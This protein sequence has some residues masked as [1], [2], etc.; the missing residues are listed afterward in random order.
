MPKS[1]NSY[2]LSGFHT[3]EHKG[4]WRDMIRGIAEPALWEEVKALEEN[5]TAMEG[6]LAKVLEDKS[7]I[8]GEYME[9]HKKKE[10]CQER[11]RQRI[12]ENERLESELS[13]S[14]ERV[15]ELE[16]ALA[17]S[18]AE[19]DKLR[20]RVAELEN[21]SLQGGEGTEWL[22]LYPICKRIRDFHLAGKSRDEIRKALLEIGHSNAQTAFLTQ[23]DT[24]VRT[25]YA[26]KKAMQRTKAKQ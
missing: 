5:Y 21:A 16:A 4:E 9:C 14:M 2:R 25:D 1:G 17:D 10:A 8:V 11:E 7:R 23:E 13:L 22:E 12:D 26:Q 15:T 19:N 24:N 3:G 6:E 20:E 18:K